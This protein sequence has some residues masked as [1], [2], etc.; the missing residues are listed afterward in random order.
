[1]STVDDIK[2]LL[3][4]KP[5]TGPAPL[6]PPPTEHQD[7]GDKYPPVSF[8]L[9]VARRLIEDLFTTGPHHT[10][11]YWRAGW[12]RWEGTHWRRLSSELE[13][14]KPVWER[15]EQVTCEDKDGDRKAWAPTTAKVNNLIEPLQLE[16]FIPDS[17]DA[18]AWLKGG[19]GPTAEH[20]VALANGLLDQTTGEFYD[21]TPTYFNTWALNFDYDPVAIYPQWEKFITETFAHDPAGGRALQ[22][23]FGY[24][25]SG[26]TDLQK[27]C[28]LIGPGGSGK[29]IIDRTLK[30]LVGGVP[31]VAAA[32]IQSLTNGFGL[33]DW[34]GKPLAVLSDSRDS[35]AIPDAV[36]SRLLSI[37]GEDAVPIEVKH[38]DNRS[39][40]LPTRVM[41]V[42][43]E[44]PSFRDS[45]GALVK[46]WVVIETAVSHRDNPDLT[47]E[48]RLR[49]ELPG[50]FLWALAGL[51]RLEEQGHFTVPQSSAETVE[52]MNDSAAPEAMFIHE[53]YE[54]TEDPTDF[55]WLSEIYPA[56]EQWTERRGNRPV[57]QTRFKGKVKA[58]GLKGVTV[59]KRERD[60]TRKEVIAG[61]L[62][63]SF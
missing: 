59:T 40:S 32:S 48:S 52:M 2:A 54:I 33:A 62:R 53:T 35:G 10:L 61:I 34:V 13:L 7:D 60:G 45:S 20:L 23:W 51:R 26:R 19:N 17:T 29:G 12:W 15:L 42:S 24:V 36:V 38:K 37:I 46:R 14:R 4:N 6:D 27:G 31:N 5:S 3:D 56:Y 1:M 18:P 43:N 49:K 63:R 21:H 57:S 22:E 39:E 58:A 16:T 30:E 47:L 11:T 25:I 50:I 55:E 9:Q 41:I 28:V 8:P 44:M